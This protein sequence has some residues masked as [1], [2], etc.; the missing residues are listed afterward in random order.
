M[1]DDDDMNEWNLR[2]EKTVGRMEWVLL[3]EEG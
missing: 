2:E 3:P 1:M